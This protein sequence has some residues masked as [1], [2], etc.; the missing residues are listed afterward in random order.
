[1]PDTPAVG[2]TIPGYEASALFGMAAP[3]NTPKDIVEKLNRETSDVSAE[4]DTQKRLVELVGEP[5]IGTPEM[6][7]SLI[8]AETER[9]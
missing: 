2:E 6:L 4:P 7:G 5:V 3:R 9:R 1:M 8:V